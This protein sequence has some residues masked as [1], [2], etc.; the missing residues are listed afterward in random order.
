SLLAGLAQRLVKPGRRLG[1]S[2][3]SRVLRCIISPGDIQLLGLFLSL[4]F[5]LHICVDFLRNLFRLLLADAP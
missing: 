2:L 5:Q 4:A 3:V 1:R